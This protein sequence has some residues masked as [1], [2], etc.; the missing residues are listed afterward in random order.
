MNG[1][2]DPLTT[3]T[4]DIQPIS[5]STLIWKVWMFGL[6][7]LLVEYE[8]DQWPS[9]YWQLPINQHLNMGSTFVNIF[10]INLDDDRNCILS[11]F[12]TRELV[13]MTN[14]SFDT[15]TP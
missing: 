5:H 11:Y 13:D 7:R 9:T 1:Q 3:V 2:P 12:D 6:T 14:G 8:L 15:D 4:P 10:I